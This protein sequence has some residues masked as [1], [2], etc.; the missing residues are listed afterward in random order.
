[1]AGE[2]GAAAAVVLSGGKD[3]R[4]E[5]VGRGRLELTGP[6]VLA[7]APPRVLAQVVHG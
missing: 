2:A 6:A 7:P 4:L 5:L 1:M 3:A